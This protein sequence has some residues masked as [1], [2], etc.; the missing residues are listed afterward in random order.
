MWGPALLLTLPWL[1][2]CGGLGGAP[3]QLPASIRGPDGK[4]YLLLDRGR[5]KGYYDT[6]GRLQRIEY[7]A[8]GDGKPDNIAY[9]DGE[10]SPRRLDV[11]EDFDGKIDRW[12]EYDPAG[13]LTKVGLSRKHAGAPDVWITPGPGDLPARKDYDDDGDMRIDRSEIFRRGLIVSVELDS[14]GDGKPD[15]WQDWST[16]R[17]EHEDLDTDADGRADRRIF[18]NP[19]GRVLRVVPVAP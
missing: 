17:L 12:E 9:H 1:S 4:T 2:A 16:G 8:N 11:D 15:R 19:Q 6:F 10:K 14:D 3:P 5:Y 18:Y 7:D 13:R